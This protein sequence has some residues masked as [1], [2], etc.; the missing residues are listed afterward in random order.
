MPCA[1]ATR[2]SNRVI[3]R[4]PT[5]PTRKRSTSR[6]TA[7]PRSLCGLGLFP[8]TPPPPS[9]MPSTWSARASTPRRKPW[10]AKFSS[11]AT[12]RTTGRL[13]SSSPVSSN[14]TTLTKRLPPNL[15]RTAPKSTNCCFRPMATSIPV[16]LT[17]RRG[18]I[19]KCW[20]STNTIQQLSAAWSRSNWA[21]SAT[22]TPPT[23]K[24][25]RACFGRWTR[26]GS[27]PSAASSTPAP[28]TPPP[29]PRSGGAPNS[30]WPG[31]TELSFPAS[32]SA[33]RPYAKRSGSSN[34]AA[35][36]STR[37]RTTPNAAESTSS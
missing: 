10:H 1:A 21:S 37:P 8:V 18:V 31:S 17:S 26:L 19:S 11:R 34:S 28:P 27:A 23:T 22:T 13:L 32:I 15:P 5:L 14:P 2:P 25:G 7:P 33:M 9:A 36:T 30:W 29:W 24:P 16:V 12:T 4:R 20:R 6:P 35:A 3:S